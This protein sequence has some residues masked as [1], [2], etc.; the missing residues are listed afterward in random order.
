MLFKTA[1]RSKFICHASHLQRR[2]PYCTVVLGTAVGTKNTPSTRSTS[3]GPYNA[4]PPT[5]PI[6]RTAILF[7]ENNPY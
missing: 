3:V 6:D 4:L 2:L 1:G 5:I 7:G